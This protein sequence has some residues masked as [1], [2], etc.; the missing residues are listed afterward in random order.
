MRM[1]SMRKLSMSCTRRCSI[2]PCINM[3]RC[4]LRQLSKILRDLVKQRS[5]ATDFVAFGGRESAS[6]HKLPRPTYSG[7]KPHRRPVIK[8][9]VVAK[10]GGQESMRAITLRFHAHL[11]VRGSRGGNKDSPIYFRCSASPLASRASSRLAVKAWR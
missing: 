8:A 7:L 10:S 3:Q 1:S 4:I 11:L 5:E 9:A 6:A 2:S